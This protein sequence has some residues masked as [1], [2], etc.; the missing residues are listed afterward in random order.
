MFHLNYIFTHIH[1]YWVPCAALCA[2][3]LHICAYITYFDTANF[4]KLLAY[5]MLLNSLCIF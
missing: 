4:C 3:I 1:A 2:N 5:F